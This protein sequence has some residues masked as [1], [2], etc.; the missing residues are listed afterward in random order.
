MG[1]S[2]AEDELSSRN[3][4]Q[5]G[6]EISR[7]LHEQHSP[8]SRARAISRDLKIIQKRPI[9]TGVGCTVKIFGER[10][11][12]LDLVRERADISSPGTIISK[13]KKLLDQSKEDEWERIRKNQASL[14]CPVKKRNE[15]L[16]D[17]KE[18]G[19]LRKREKDPRP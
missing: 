3:K 2:K 12:E 14:R 18:R 1:T 19:K 11:I 16:A 13:K 7:L 17:P 15:A 8:S 6:G 10:C 5:K 4:E 9:V